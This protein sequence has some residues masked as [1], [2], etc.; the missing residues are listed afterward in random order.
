MS[1]KGLNMVNFTILAKKLCDD[2]M[3]GRRTTDEPAKFESA[4]VKWSL[5]LSTDW[6]ESGLNLRAAF[7][8]RGLFTLAI[9]MKIHVHGQVASIGSARIMGMLM[10]TTQSSTTKSTRSINFPSLTNRHHF[11]DINKQ[12][13]QCCLLQPLNI[14]INLASGVS[15]TSLRGKG[16]I[17]MVANPKVDGRGSNAHCMDIVTRSGKMVPSQVDNSCEIDVDEFGEE[18]RKMDGEVGMKSLVDVSSE[19]AV[20]V[21]KK[22]KKVNEN[23]I[24]IAK[25]YSKPLPPFPRRLAKQYFYA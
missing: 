20:M 5:Q 25:S 11:K 14:F 12:N 21:L 18:E 24:D 2:S 10:S 3:D 16:P 17:G 8:I 9:G 4:P 6:I 13:P 23:V 22:K 19:E 7:G 1:S 15:L